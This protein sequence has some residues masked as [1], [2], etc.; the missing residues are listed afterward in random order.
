VPGHHPPAPVHHCQARRSRGVRRDHRDQGEGVQE[1]VEPAPGVRPQEGHRQAGLHLLVP[2]QPNDQLRLWH[3]CCGGHQ[4][5]YADDKLRVGGPVGELHV[6]AQQHEA[7]LRRRHHPGGEQVRQ[8]PTGQN[9]RR[10]RGPLHR[11][12]G[13]PA[14]LGGRLAHLLDIFQP[15]QDVYCV[16]E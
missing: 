6:P 13:V 7:G 15:T 9:L 11:C 14:P 3:L 12:G 10:E 1:R 2:Q 16:K 4:R 8:R 5:V